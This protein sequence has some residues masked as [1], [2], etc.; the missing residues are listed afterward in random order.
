M[1]VVIYN[2]LLYPEVVR[3][4]DEHL[5][6]LSHYNAYAEGSDVSLDR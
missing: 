4:A 1:Y 2:D 6:I 3:S 5:L